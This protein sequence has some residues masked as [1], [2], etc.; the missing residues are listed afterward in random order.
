MPEV[1]EE[2]QEE[3]QERLFETMRSLGTSGEY[4]DELRRRIRAPQRPSL[5]RRIRAWFAAS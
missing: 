4:I 5:L 3:A 1:T 2:A